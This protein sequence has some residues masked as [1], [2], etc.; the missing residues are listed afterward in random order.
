V[1]GR[2]ERVRPGT[3]A[4]ARLSDCIRDAQGEDPLAP[5]TV[6]VRSPVVALDLRRSLAE[7]GAFAGVRFMPMSRLVEL[8]GSPAAESRA[9]AGRPLTAAAL[10][11]AVRVALGQ[12]PGVFAGVLEHP[13][14]EESLV[15][16]YR[17]L[18]PLGAED[19]AAL[20]SQSERARDVLRIVEAVERR[21]R[22]GWYD[23][24]DLVHA[25]IDGLENES[26]D[27]EPVGSVVLHLPDPLPSSQ[28]A[29][30]AALGRRVAVAVLVAALEDEV[31]DRAGD[32]LV[33]EL[34]SAGLELASAGRE[35]AGSSE[36]PRGRSGGTA[37]GFDQAIGAP[38]ADE[39]ARVAVRL[40]LAHAEAGGSLGR[41]AIAVPG[42]GAAAPSL[43]LVEELLT[44][45]GVPWTGPSRATLAETPAGRLLTECVELLLERERPFDRG[46]VIRWL[47]SPALSA[48][49][50]LF[51]GLPSVDPD[52]PD[53]S[54]RPPDAGRRP[55]NASRRPPAG[56]FDRCSRRAGV[57]GGRKEW[58]SRLIRLAGRPAPDTGR[59]A[60]NGARVVEDEQVA[61]E[62]RVARDLLTIVDRLHRQ[63]ELL[64]GA[65]GW[66]ELGERLVAV[67]ELILPPGDE[68]DRVV[69]ALEI[70]EDCGELE[71]LGPGG[72]AIG[73]D[74]QL[75]RRQVGSALG[76]ALSASAAGAGRFGAGPVVGTIASLAGLETDLVVVVGC[77]EG[78][79]PARTPEDP[80]VTELER[81]AVR[82][83]A[84]RERVEPRYRRLV[85]TLLAGA[86]RAVAVYARVERGAGRPSH[87]SRWLLG[88]L[89]DGRIDEIPSFTAAVGKIAAGAMAPLDGG[90]VE[91]ALAHAAGSGGAGRAAAGVVATAGD[92]ARRFDAERERRRRGLSRFAGMVGRRP[93]NEDA[94]GDILSPTRI[95][96][97]AKCPLQFMFERR[98]RLGILEAP[99]RLDTIS[100]RDK[101]TLIHGV[102]E[103]FVVETAVAS[104]SFSG[105]DGAAAGR[106]REIAEEELAA[107]EERGITGK[108]LFWAM[109]RA[110]LLADLE[111]FVAIEADR[112]AETGGRPI[113]AESSFGD[114]VAPALT[115]DLGNRQLRFR[116]QIDRIDQERDGIVRVIDYKSGKGSGYERIGTDPFDNGRHLQLPIYAKAAAALVGVDESKVVAEYRFCSAS[117]RFKRVSI[118]L[119]P[120]L[121]D[122]FVDV[123]RTLTDVVEQGVYVPRP[124]AES[125]RAA[126]CAMCDFEAVCRLDRSARWEQAVSE[127]RLA[128]Y[129]ALVEAG[130]TPSDTG[131]VPP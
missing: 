118:A 96:A 131:T 98:L 127:A 11:A 33:R 65:T 27:L 53:G 80:L 45:A 15:R 51:A 115:I 55:P 125:T 121:H 46:E 26:V 32:A 111:R 82:V 3:A 101:G 94:L 100:A 28:V 123:L 63:A 130:R 17:M 68:R 74:A 52:G 87:P 117:A 8:L 71:A 97:V 10:G 106:L 99:E 102:L 24:E 76:A 122:A 54:G 84:E 18:R 38:D 48:A 67:A 58:G 126:N 66:A 124:G 9:L 25:A 12:L 83:L 29:L 95:E 120:Q 47:S 5:V 88:D 72:P 42:S 119:T 104:P 37:R 114:G 34:A 50:A 70:V 49:A 20:R 41:T 7:R 85:L 105:W 36:A 13:A 21:Q 61:E 116:G 6:V 1:T 91:L 59:P 19:R 62:G 79:L 31:A 90:E 107:A 89:F 16:A 2:I 43:G 93:E 129:V 4:T 35:P 75:R 109:E 112:L 39:E 64:D 14:T 56:A 40:L 108:A 128:D 44:A 77:R 78:Q 86:G 81:D 92:L 73:R 103:R 30:V 110:E 22:G 60:A 113:R 69:S 57:V 23:L